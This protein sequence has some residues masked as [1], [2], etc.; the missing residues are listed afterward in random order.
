MSYDQL[1]SILLG[2]KVRVNRIM[3]KS[4][5]DLFVHATENV[6]PALLQRRGDN[7]EDIM[8]TRHSMQRGTY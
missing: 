5:N 7:K 2:T 4:F 1:L 6:V 8:S 3:G